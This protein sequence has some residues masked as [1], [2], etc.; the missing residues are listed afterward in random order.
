MNEREY[1]VKAQ[2]ADALANAA[3]NW[4]KRYRY[5]T[6]AREFRRMAQTMATARRIMFYG[7]DAQEATQQQVGD[8]AD[9]ITRTPERRI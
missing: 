1:L 7:A 3:D 6:A 2:E 8:M 9:K 5:E 4:L